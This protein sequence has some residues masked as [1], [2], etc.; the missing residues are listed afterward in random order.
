MYTL[1][2]YHDGNNIRGLMV[3]YYDGRYESHTTRE[4][5]FGH[6]IGSND[7]ELQNS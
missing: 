4:L 2:V 7:K 5:K 1:D 3:A 6:I